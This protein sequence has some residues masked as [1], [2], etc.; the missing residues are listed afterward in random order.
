MNTSE[1]VQLL[2]DSGESRAQRKQLIDPDDEFDDIFPS[3]R[4]D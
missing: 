4:E 1:I 3:H 2:G